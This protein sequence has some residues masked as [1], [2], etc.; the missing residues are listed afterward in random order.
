MENPILKK[1]EE[2]KFS[3]KPIQPSIKP[4]NFQNIQ[5]TTNMFQPR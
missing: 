2:L 4:I 1:E 5:N 3:N